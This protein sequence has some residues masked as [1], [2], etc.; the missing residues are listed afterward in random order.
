[1][2]TTTDFITSD[3]AMEVRCPGCR[4]CVVIWAGLIPQHFPK[5]VTIEEAERRLICSTCGHKGARI[6][7]YVHEVPGNGS[8]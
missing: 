1:M 8:L 4:R 5:P 3:K 7:V 2:Q 6:A